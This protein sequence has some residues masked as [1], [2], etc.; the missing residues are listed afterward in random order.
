MA[1]R[2]HRVDC[3]IKTH[4]LEVWDVTPRRHKGS[5]HFEVTVPPLYSADI[6]SYELFTRCANATWDMRQG[7]GD[8]RHFGGAIKWTGPHTCRVLVWTGNGR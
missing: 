8:V 7:A 6:R 3:P 4:L 2:L 5:R 1:E